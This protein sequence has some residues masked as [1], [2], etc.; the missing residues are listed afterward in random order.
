ML[1]VLPQIPKVHTSQ[2]IP[3]IFPN[4]PKS[5]GYIEKRPY[6]VSLVR[7]LHIFNIGPWP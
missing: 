2:F 7:G 1:K 5:L 4:W 6:Q 3:P